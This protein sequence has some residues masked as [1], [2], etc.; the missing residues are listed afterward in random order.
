[1]KERK[2]EE[3]IRFVE[4]VVR[5]YDKHSLGWIHEKDRYSSESQKFTTAQLL[6]KFRALP[7]KEIT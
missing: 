2:A 3:M 4:W 7:P 5:N 1:M 6:E